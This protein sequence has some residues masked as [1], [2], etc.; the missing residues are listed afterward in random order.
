MGFD[1]SVKS[2]ERAADEWDPMAGPLYAGQDFVSWHRDLI[3]WNAALP[4]PVH[5][6]VPRPR[7]GQ[8]VTD[9]I[10]LVPHG[11]EGTHSIAFGLSPGVTDR[12]VEPHAYWLEVRDPTE[13]PDAVLQEIHDVE[14]SGV[15]AYYGNELVAQGHGPV[16]VVD[17]EPSTSDLS[18]ALFDEGHGFDAL[19]GHLDVQVK[20]RLANGG[21]EVKY[22][23]SSP[24]DANPYVVGGN[25]KWEAPEIWVDNQLMDGYA[26]RPDPGKEP[27]IAF[28]DNR[29]YTRVHN[30]GPGDA[31]DVEVTFSL[32]A[33]WRTLGGKDNFT[34]YKKVIIPVIPA[35]EYRDAMVI[36]RPTNHE[37]VHS[38]VL[39]ELTTRGV[40]SNSEDNIAQRNFT[41]LGSYHSSPYDL[42][43]ARFGFTAPNLEGGSGEKEVIHFR[44]EGIPAKWDWSLK[45]DEVQLAEGEHVVGSIELQPNPEA[46]SC[47]EHDVR[48]S[49]WAVREDTLVQLG[50]STVQVALRERTK[51]EIEGRPADHDC[52]SSLPWAC[53]PITVTGC[54]AP[55]RPDGLVRVALVDPYGVPLYHNAPLDPSGCFK[56][57]EGVGYGG[58]WEIRGHYLGDECAAP[59]TSGEKI[60]V[61]LEMSP[62]TDGDGVPNAEEIQGAADGDG[63]PNHLDPDSDNDGISDGDEMELDGDR[64]GLPPM[65]DPD[66]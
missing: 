3:G 36:W 11:K 34:E 27:P 29:V 4:G 53:M 58:D 12:T 59:S 57:E 23:Y 61:S 63:I 22:K 46:P 38:C 51:R 18:D 45:P 1:H 10:E 28:E 16:R 65:V 42:V 64:D 50:G 40:D 55:A 32:S 30:A 6:F 9:S 56:L 2:E 17:A 48:L 54:T 44:P 20:R 52:N 25:P 26:S 24:A 43:S 14:K 60:F 66:E 39:V 7:P 31:Y 15:L 49:S 33:P 47:S 35:G 37:D 13:G 21:F 19:G 62:D 41:V 8:S 5:L